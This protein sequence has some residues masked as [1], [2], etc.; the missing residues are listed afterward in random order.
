MAL[1]E[2]RERRVHF[3]RHVVR[4][5]ALD[6]RV[7]RT[8]IEEPPDPPGFDFA[9]SRAV[10]PPREVLPLAVRWVHAE[11]EV[12]IWTRESP[13]EVGV[14]AASILPISADRGG[15]LRAPAAAVSRG[16]LD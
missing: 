1:V 10:G 14:P 15:I 12:W 2:I 8:R 3:L 13:L 16:T 11:G 5:L 4:V 6:L 9:L 7:I